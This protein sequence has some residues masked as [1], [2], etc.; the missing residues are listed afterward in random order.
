[1]CLEFPGGLKAPD[2]ALRGVM[3]VLEVVDTTRVRYAMSA[4]YESLT[5]VL[6]SIG[7]CT[8]IIGAHIES[9]S[10]MTMTARVCLTCLSD[11]AAGRS[12]RR[13]HLATL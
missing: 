9:V 2:E 1:M 8:A 11:S 4:E 7:T 12:R 5:Y 3:E 10:L 13:W 6:V